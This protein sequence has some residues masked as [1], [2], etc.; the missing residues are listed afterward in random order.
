MR[1]EHGDPGGLQQSGHHHPRH[2]V[3]LHDEAPDGVGGGAGVRRRARGHVRPP[4]RGLGD[5][6]RAAT[7]SLLG[8][9][10]LE[11][12]L[13][14]LV[15]GGL[16][17]DLVEMAHDSAAGGVVPCGGV[18]RGGDGDHRQGVLGVGFADLLHCPQAAHD[19][20]VEV[21]EDEVKALLLH[22][23]ERLRAVAA[24]G[25]LRLRAQQLPPVL[26]DGALHGQ[27]VCHAVLHQQ[28][29]GGLRRRQRQ[30]RR[31]RLLLLLKRFPERLGL[32]V[33][34][35]HARHGPAAFFGA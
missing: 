25:Q 13:H 26:F 6:G 24:R 15:A 12:G 20:H 22:R 32:G 8:Q 23:L 7:G 35:A 9:V 31:H 28:H 1:L 3:V 29:V 30:R 16:G 19:R 18:L 21:H 4:N 33:P 14:V 2:L 11:D 5:A 17:D 27:L 34:P 10:A